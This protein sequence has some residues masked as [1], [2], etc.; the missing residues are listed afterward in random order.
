MSFADELLTK[1]LDEE[2]KAKFDSEPMLGGI[3][4]PAE[5]VGMMAY[6]DGKLVLGD[7]TIEATGYNPAAV[8][9]RRMVV[10]GPDGPP[11]WREVHSVIIS[12]RGD[13][14]A[15][16]ELDEQNRRAQVYLLGPKEYWRQV[17]V[18]HYTYGPDGH[19][20]TDEEFEQEWA[21]GEAE[22]TS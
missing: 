6:E 15:Q 5:F 4:E 13:G 18:G 16:E 12:V 9:V 7:L 17:Q 8:Y 3:M 21:E 10:K 19:V 11:Y 20:M 1:M 2:A 14:Y 22:A